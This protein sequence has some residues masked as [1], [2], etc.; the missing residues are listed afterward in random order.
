MRRAALAPI[1]ALAAVA[2]LLLATGC[3][4]TREHDAAPAAAA[5]PKRTA[6]P[7]DCGDA[8][9][10]DTCVQRRPRQPDD[11]EWECSERS[12]VTVCRGGLA[13]AGVSAGAPERGWVCGAHRGVTDAGA[14]PRVCVD[15]AP[16]Y[17]SAE[18]WSCRFAYVDD[19]PRRECQRSPSTRVGD[20][21]ASGACPPGTTCVGDRC[22]APTPNPSCFFDA[23][24]T[25][26]QHCLFGSCRAS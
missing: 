16:D 19:L 6:P 11:G 24:C 20:P 18:G 21:C 17:P 25:Q 22:L 9:A 3:A 12:G 1:A 26:G 7:W 5:A 13:A 10:A 4:K 23:E 15:F 14:Y 2:S 8:G